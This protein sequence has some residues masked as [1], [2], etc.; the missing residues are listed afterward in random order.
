MSR[1]TNVVPQSPRHLESSL[2]VL[3]ASEI[4]YATKIWNCLKY[5]CTL[6]YRYSS[7]Q[8]SNSIEPIMAG[9]FGIDFQNTADELSL[10][11]TE[12]L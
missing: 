8:A 6:L 4:N 7:R 3:P 9:P 1:R 12:N 10:C 11:E 5:L 2:D